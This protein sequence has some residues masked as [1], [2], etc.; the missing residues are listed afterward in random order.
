[1]RLP[2]QE[3]PQFLPVGESYPPFLQMSLTIRHQDHS[4]CVYPGKGVLKLLR[5]HQT[6]FGSFLPERNV[7]VCVCVLESVNVHGGEA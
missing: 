7:C 4:L 2:T 6:N 5:R 1:M 3:A